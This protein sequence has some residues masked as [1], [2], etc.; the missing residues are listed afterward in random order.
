MDEQI[1]HLWINCDCGRTFMVFG[2]CFNLVLK[3]WS[4]VD[5]LEISDVGREPSFSI[6]TL[7]SKKLTVD[8]EYK[9]ENLML[10]DM[11]LLLLYSR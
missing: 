5:G 6:V 10:D 11:S 3:Y 2:G 4:I 8:R 7:A 9:Y 1:L